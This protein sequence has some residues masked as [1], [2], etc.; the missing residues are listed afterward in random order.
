MA[1]PSS[2]QAP[3]KAPGQANSLWTF[4]FVLNMLV[5]HFMFAGYTSLITIVPSYV[6][7]QGGQEWQ[8]G[9]IIG[10]FGLVAMFIRPFAGR[11]VNKFGAKQI[12]V[13]GTIIIAIGS[14]LYIVSPGPW[15]LVPIRMGQGIGIAMAPVATSTIVA[16]LAPSHR[17]AE[18][19]SYMG[20]SINVAFLY[21]PVV[22]SLILGFAGFKYA[23]M[24]SCS[25][26]LMA[27]L[28]ASRLSSA[29]VSPPVAVSTDAPTETVPLIS[30]GALF[31]AI[32]F[33]AYTFTTAPINTFLPILA[34]ER[35]LGNPGLYFTVWSV[36]SIAGMM[37][38]G[39]VADRFGRATVIVPGLMLTACAMFL[40][41]IANIPAML[42]G[43]GFLAGVGFGLIQPGIQSLTIDRVSLRERSSGVAT[44][45]QAWDIAGSGGAFIIGPLGGLIGVA[46][47][48]GVTGVGALVGVVGFVIGNKRG[49]ALTPGRQADIVESED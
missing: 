11:W 26:A 35:G 40:L 43:A 10:S 3:G 24:F 1:N 36:T 2:G 44:L 7:H 37:V 9:I 5:G 34:E 19:M 29:R 4:D 20:A 33:M 21:A 12:A 22:A 16:N 48:F 8:L 31:P 13:I 32:V 14:L 17:R 49:P 46:N 47:S 27:A 42:W 25:S 6:L 38:S 23:F 30:R 28:L 18:A 39:P 41:N 15:W 45:Q